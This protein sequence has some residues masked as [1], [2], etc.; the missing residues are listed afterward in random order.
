MP[1]QDLQRVVEAARRF[2]EVA[3]STA[4]GPTFGAA[5]DAYEA[6]RLPACS[7]TTIRVYGSWLRALRCVELDGRLLPA[8]HLAELTPAMVQRIFQAHPTGARY[9]AA[10][11]ARQLGRVVAHAIETGRWHGTNP[12]AAFRGPRPRRREHPLDP[13]QARKLRAA[14]EV[15]E[16]GARSARLLLRFLLLSGWRIGEARALRVEHVRARAWERDRWAEAELPETKGGPQ[17]R[18]ISGGALSVM[19]IASAARSVGYAFSDDG[20][21]PVGYRSCLSTLERACTHAGLERR[22][23]HDLRHTL[24]TYLLRRGVACADVARLL[25]HDERTTLIYSHA[26][27]DDVRRALRLVDELEENGAA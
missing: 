27:G 17:R 21:A 19:L 26:S 5:L 14:L 13:V 3:E 1:P 12:A 7:A 18:P 8:M 6:E 24:A 11:V 16:V 10:Q 23:P 4:S 2:L 20:T 25:G 15:P 9:N 22:V